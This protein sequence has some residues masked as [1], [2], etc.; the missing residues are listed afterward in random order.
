MQSLSSYLTYWF[1]V[2]GLEF[3]HNQGQFHVLLNMIYLSAAA[4]QM[5]VKNN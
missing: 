2:T 1:F 3:L 4:I 5:I